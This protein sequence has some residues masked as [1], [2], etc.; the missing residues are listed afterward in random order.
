ML[1]PSVVIV[2]GSSQRQAV[3]SPRTPDVV[4]DGGNAGA[5]VALAAGG[6]AL[7]AT[8]D[9]AFAPSAWTAVA[10]GATQAVAAGTRRAF[11]QAGP[12]HTVLSW[13]FA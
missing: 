4:I 5:S 9:N 12:D 8:V 2:K 10:A 13:T 1:D 3:L 7:T 6:G 11:R